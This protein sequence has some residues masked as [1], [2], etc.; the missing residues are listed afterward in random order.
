MTTHR[1]H[2]GGR[3]RAWLGAHLGGDAETGN[4]ALRRML[5]GGG[6]VILIYYL[7]PA[8]LLVIAPN[9]VILLLALVTIF[10]LEGLRLRGL[11]E[12]PTLRPYEQHRLAS[13]AYFA[14]A[15]VLAVLLF[16]PPIAAAVVLGTSLIDPLIGELRRSPSYRGT[17]PGI[18]V[19]L[20]TAFAFLAFIG[21][22]EWAPLPALSLAALAAVLA[23]LAERPKWA[24]VDDDLAMT[25]VPA[26]AVYVIVGLAPGFVH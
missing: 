10:I 19:A 21:F 6:A 4:R 25:L 1:L 23:L 2:G 24:L 17:Y 8:D 14:L 3:F 16:P 13:Y 11:L 20:Y 5:H 7:L 18:P 15:L 9:F 12:V 22:G 26:V